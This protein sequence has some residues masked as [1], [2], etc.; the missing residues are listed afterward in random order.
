[1]G[2][3]TSS[4]KIG[5]LGR[6]ELISYHGRKMFSHQKGNLQLIY[7]LVNKLVDPENHQF[8]METSLPTPMTARVYVNLPE[9]MIPKLREVPYIECY[10]HT[11]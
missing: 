10:I 8:L 11:R 9:G 4:E 3:S 2:E 5:H 7:P 1:M 6:W